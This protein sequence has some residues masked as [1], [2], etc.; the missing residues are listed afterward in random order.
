ML[1]RSIEEK[2][3]TIEE[4]RSRINNIKKAIK[5]ISQEDKP[6]LVEHFKKL[7]QN[8]EKL[9]DTLIDHD[10]S[11]NSAHWKE[12]VSAQ[13]MAAKAM[14]MI[15]HTFTHEEEKRNSYM[16]WCYY[17]IKQ[18]QSCASWANSL[19]AQADK[20]EMGVTATLLYKK[21][22]RKYF[23]AIKLLCEI[24]SSIAR[25][26]KEDYSTALQPDVL[27]GVC[28]SDL[29]SAREMYAE[30]LSD[31]GDD[32]Y[33]KGNWHTAINYYKKCIQHYELSI[34]DLE[35]YPF[36]MKEGVR[37]NADNID[38]TI[39][40]L[41][42]CINE[43]KEVIAV[44]QEKMRKGLKRPASTAFETE[45]PSQRRRSP[46]FFQASSSSIAADNSNN[47][48]LQPKNLQP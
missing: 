15:A 21:G 5:Q 42:E 39:A 19:I 17:K 27:T 20:S 16:T 38:D 30:H 41:R 23:F 1:S 28:Y 35:K 36:L 26:F 33:L 47:A 44:I 11:N 12:I 13:Q 14:Q 25:L 7:A 6:K 37:S 10:P 48:S 8:C 3:I 45:S 46:R 29:A 18:A 2:P 22:I 40:L 32:V 9:A 31:Q 43:E 34:S 24:P 4:L